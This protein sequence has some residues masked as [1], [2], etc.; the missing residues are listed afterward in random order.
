MQHISQRLT[1][2]NLKSDP[3]FQNRTD[4]KTNGFIAKHVHSWTLFYANLI[5]IYIKDKSTKLKSNYCLC[6]SNLKTTDTNNDNNLLGP[7][8]RIYK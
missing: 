7:E 5:A 8:R 6:I 1:S 4:I 3:N 2:S